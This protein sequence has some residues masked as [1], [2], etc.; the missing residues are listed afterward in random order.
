MYMYMYMYVCMDVCTRL[1][2]LHA[3][4][5]IV[6]SETCQLEVC[7]VPQTALSEALLDH[8]EEQRG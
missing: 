7:E 6:T 3:E 5:L 1:S 8:P 2:A 4:S